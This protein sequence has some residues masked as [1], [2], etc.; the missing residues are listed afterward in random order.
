MTHDDVLDALEV[1]LEPFALCEIRG[2]GSLGLGRRQH[3]VLHYVLAGDGSISIDG[4]PSIA[5][6]AG[7]VVLI[8]AFS[9]HS[10]HAR[11]G[12]TGAV[13]DCRPI[14]AGLQHLSVG[15]GPA[16]LTAVCGRITVVYRGLRGTM[17]LLRAPV[18]EHLA[19]DDRVR[20]A[21]EDFVA[22]LAR[23]TV[24]SRALARSLLLQC[25]IILLRRR[26][27]SDDPSMHWMRGLGDEALWAPVRSMLDQPELGHTVESL[28]DLAGLSRTTFAER[29]QVAYGSGPIE[30]LRT[31][32]MRRAAELLARSDLPVKRVA[33]MVGYHSRTYFSRA[34]RA[35]HGLPPD[36]FRQSL[37]K[38]TGP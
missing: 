20:G 6:R 34:F 29:F 27:G 37:A 2:D 30:L 23:P 18:V 28:A 24:G 10:L 3:A 21:L 32:R 26:L 4:H 36:A 38:P 15:S 31:I 12:A 17:D 5:T 11:G 35:E 22:E 1:T 19:A 14:E 13:P 16:T 25:V 8:P 33:G 9:A 7:T